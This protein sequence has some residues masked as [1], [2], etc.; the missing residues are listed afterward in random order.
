MTSDPDSPR[1]GPRGG[2]SGTGHLVLLA[3]AASSP[4][5][6][7]GGGVT[8]MCAV[9]GN[10]GAA[11]S[12]LLFAAV[13]ASFVIGPPPGE[14]DRHQRRD[15]YSYSP[16]GL[17]RAGEVSQPFISVVAGNTIQIGRYGLFGANFRDFI[18]AKFEVKAD[19]WIWALAAWVM[20]RGRP[21]RLR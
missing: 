20:A 2:L 11:L 18:A 10:L 9:G 6:V 3:V 7:L 17:G 21:R 13:L 5:T 12:H 8:T 14:Q 19:W 1:S 15:I 16:R 4:S